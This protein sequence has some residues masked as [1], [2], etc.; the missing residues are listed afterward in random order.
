MGKLRVL[1]PDPRFKI[2]QLC[3]SHPGLQ[4]DTVSPPETHL[5]RQKKADIWEDL[6]LAS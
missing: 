5:V 1:T 6:E 2:V 3:L 4:L